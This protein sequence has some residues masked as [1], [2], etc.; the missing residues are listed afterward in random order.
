MTAEA[1]AWSR[2][3]C[4]PPRH[5]LIWETDFRRQTLGWLDASF[6]AAGFEINSN[7]AIQP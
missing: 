2:S 1:S 7:L 6:R 5:P 4:R 3:E